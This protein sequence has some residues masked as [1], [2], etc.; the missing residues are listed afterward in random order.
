MEHGGD[1]V[2]YY[3]I[4]A[5]APFLPFVSFWFPQSTAPNNLYCYY[6]H[7]SRF[8]LVVLIACLLELTHSCH[9]FHTIS[10]LL[11]PDC[12]RAT[13][14]MIAADETQTQISHLPPGDSP[15]L[16]LT[17]ATPEER[18]AVLHLNS[19]A[20]KGPLDVTGYIAREDHLLQQQLTH[21]R[22][23]C[24]VLVDSREPANQRTI[25]SSC[26]TFRKNG[27][28]ARDGVVT[29]VTAHGIGSVY[30]RPEFRGKGYARRMMEELKKTLDDG[31]V[32]MKGKCKDKAMF[33]VLFSD[34]G[35]R[36]YA[37]F[38]WVP[39][40]SAHVQLPPIGLAELRR[41]MPGIDLPATR[42]LVGAD[43]V[44]KSMCNETAVQRQREY[45]RLVSEKTP[46]A[47]KVAIDPDFQHLVWHWA[48]EEF[49]AE[50]LCQERGRPLIKGA[51]HDD[52]GR[53]GVYCAW[54][55]N[56]GETPEENT[57]YIL[58]WAYD[59]PTTPAETE[60]TIE[61]MAAILRRAQHEAHV[62]GM[63]RV[64]FWNPA[65]LMQKAVSMLD[66]TIEVIHREESSIA[67]LRWSGAEQEGKAVEWVWNEKYAWC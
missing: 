23:V 59:E 17:P 9:S 30:S 62:W 52:A 26:E 48:R 35:K 56:F 67:C 47:T 64:E 33:S 51:G 1:I 20:W 28:V 61:A 45:L 14:T 46:G 27:L 37:Q 34:I 25:L 19:R 8:E 55:R 60:T 16:H 44:R 29:D 65:P 10:T 31:A 54:N 32:G 53:A 42:D 40:P 41:D 18:L 7:P 2:L 15:S 24:W 50:R 6:Q 57:L 63:A 12:L 49:Y 58:R 5:L 3:I 13:Y 11:F 4:V 66:P 36:F 21:G 39:F 22:L 43:A 38:G